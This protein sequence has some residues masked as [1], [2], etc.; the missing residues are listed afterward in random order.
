MGEA[1]DLKP[2][3]WIAS[4]RDD[5]RSFSREV[6]DVFGFALFQAQ[7]GSKHVAAKPMKGYAGA[8]V[9][10]V[11]EDEDGNTFRAIYTVKFK[12]A[13]YVL[14][15]FQKKSKKGI[16]TPQRDIDLIRARLGL[17]KTH[18]EQWSVA[19]EKAQK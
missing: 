4:S 9:L 19:H 3:F 2:L 11:V 13:V 12:E 8:G 17:A 14:H 1:S 7:M 5:L 16:K 15:V 6:R 18:Y 10:E